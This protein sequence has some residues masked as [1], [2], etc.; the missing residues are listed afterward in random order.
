M[1]K[2]N[3]FCCCNAT[4]HVTS[5]SNTQNASHYDATTDLAKMLRIHTAAQNQCI[6]TYIATNHKVPAIKLT[7]RVP[8]LK[9]LVKT[10]QNN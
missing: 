7:K 1:L 3:Q 6:D 5:A 8:T 10:E 2:N 9:T 4:T